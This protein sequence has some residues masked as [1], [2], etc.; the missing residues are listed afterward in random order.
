[1]SAASKDKGTENKHFETRVNASYDMKGMHV[2]IKHA[3]IF[4]Y[5]VK[6]HVGA[7]KHKIFLDYLSSY[8]NQMDI[9]AKKLV[10]FAEKNFIQSESTELLDGFL[11]FLPVSKAFKL[12]VKWIKKGLLTNAP[13]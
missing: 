9:N 13:K 11:H 6:Q 2:K 4:V 3:L 8:T 1:M 7:E 10:A 12:R 5:K